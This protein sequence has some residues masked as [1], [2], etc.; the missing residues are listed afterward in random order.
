M[1]RI[2][3]FLSAQ[4]NNLHTL[5]KLLN[6]PPISSNV[7]LSSILLGSGAPVHS[8]MLEVTALWPSGLMFDSPDW[9]EGQL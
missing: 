6:E 3:Y 4:L 8:C 1:L 5:M 9:G 7:S 2:C